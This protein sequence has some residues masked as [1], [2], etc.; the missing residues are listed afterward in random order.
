MGTNNSSSKAAKNTTTTAPAIP[1]AASP[2]PPVTV[3]APA[4]PPASPPPASPVTAGTPPPDN[5]VLVAYVGNAMSTL[6]VAESGLEV[7]PPALTSAQKRRAAKLHAGGTETVS[8][9][10]TL[11]RQY[12]V[13]SSVLQVSAMLLALNDA[14]A[15]E[16]LIARLEAFLKHVND[17]YF[18]WR[19]AAWAD[20]MQF[21]ALLQR[22]AL[23]DGA[24]EASLAPVAQFF[25]KR[26]TTK[27]AAGAVKVP[28]RTAKANK[29]AVKR[30]AQSAP[31]LLAPGVAE[32]GQPA[33]G[34]SAGNWGNGASGQVGAG[35]PAGNGATNGGSTQAASGG[36]PGAPTNG[37]GAAGGSTTS[38]S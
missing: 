19:S 26:H 34:G 1:P 3:T 32:T 31:E 35:V 4:A 30:L 14:Q 20:A 7:D 16:P 9:L 18:L 22:R 29:A 36:S 33:A 25:A 12:G 6:D 23:V 27:A 21:Y 24:I 13:E 2:T 15:L 38:H 5:A 17:L 28:K 8:Q 11:A 37:A 10:A